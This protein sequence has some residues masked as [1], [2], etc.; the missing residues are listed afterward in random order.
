[1]ILNDDTVISKNTVVF[2]L[3]LKPLLNVDK[4]NKQLFELAIQRNNAAPSLYYILC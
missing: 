4:K 1:L 2:K 3:T